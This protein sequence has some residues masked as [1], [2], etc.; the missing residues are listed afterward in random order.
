MRAVPQRPALR[1]RADARASIGEATPAMG[2]P[3]IE[4]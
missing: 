4:P 3:P 1:E 2:T